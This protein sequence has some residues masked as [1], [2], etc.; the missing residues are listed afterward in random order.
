MGLSAETKTII[1]S[2]WLMLLLLLLSLINTLNKIRKK[3]Q[4]SKQKKAQ[5]VNLKTLHHNII[6]QTGFNYL[7]GSIPDK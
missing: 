5:G 4:F 7:W 6:I 3:I 2:I 1:N